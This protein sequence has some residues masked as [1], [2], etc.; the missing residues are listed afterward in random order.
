M[1]TSKK[2]YTQVPQREMIRFLTGSEKAIRNNWKDR[3]ET[4]QKK[5]HLE[6]KK[7]EVIVLKNFLGGKK[8]GCNEDKMKQ[9][10]QEKK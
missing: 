5:I 4:E 8:V 3:N 7:S 9:A 6:R 10:E 1:I 2:E